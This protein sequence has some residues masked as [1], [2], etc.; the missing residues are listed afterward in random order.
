MNRGSREQVENTELVCCD[1][2]QPGNALEGRYFDWILDIT[3][4]TEEHIS[5]LT[6]SGVS[7]GNYLR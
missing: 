6:G 3:A 7:F 1:R 2:T 5:A 4:Y